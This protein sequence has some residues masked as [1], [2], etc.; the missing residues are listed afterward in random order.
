MLRSAVLLDG[1]GA[2]DSPDPADEDES[3]ED[4]NDTDDDGGLL[5]VFVLGEETSNDGGPAG[6]ENR[7]DEHDEGH[8]G[9]KL[10]LVNF[11]VVFHFSNFIDYKLTC[12]FND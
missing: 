5:L 1:E 7:E 10:D 11:L 4:L 8:L 9:V 12:R 3:E 6:G 2:H